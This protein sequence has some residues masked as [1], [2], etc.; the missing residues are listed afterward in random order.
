MFPHYISLLM[1]HKAHSYHLKMHQKT[2][3][4][5]LF[6]Q[7]PDVARRSHSAVISRETKTRIKQ[8]TP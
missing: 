3:H 6:L 4:W 7:E 1:W 5:R 8:E 2:Q